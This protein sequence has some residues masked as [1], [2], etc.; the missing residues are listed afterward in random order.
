MSTPK[1]NAGMNS[2]NPIFV[3]NKLFFSLKLSL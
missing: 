2:E 1:S 3:K